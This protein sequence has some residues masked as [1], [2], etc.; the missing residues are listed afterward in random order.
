MHHRADTDALDAEQ[1][2]NRCAGVV[3]DR[4][5][6]VEGIDAGL[7]EDKTGNDE[8]VDGPGIDHGQIS[9]G[10]AYTVDVADSAAA[11]GRD[12]AEIGDGVVAADVD[13]DRSEE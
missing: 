11:R 7:V 4:Q 5:V 13:A 6:G 10:G 9:A 3:G 2:V 8:P 1:P 12:G